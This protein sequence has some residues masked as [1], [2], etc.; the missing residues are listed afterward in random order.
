MATSISI[1]FEGSEQ[2]AQSLQK[3]LEQHVADSAQL[4]VGTLQN[5]HGKITPVKT[6]RARDGWTETHT[7]T[8]F[9]VENKVPYIGYLEQGRSK[10]A[11]KGMIGP[12][13]NKLKGKI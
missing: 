1:T 5:K 7:K 4:V 8:D 3:T 11:P 13:L 6:G 2:I 10:Q 9:K 12:A